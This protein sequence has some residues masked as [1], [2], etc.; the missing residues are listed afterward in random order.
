LWLQLRLLLSLLIWWRIGSAKALWRR[1][2][3]RI[4]GISEPCKGRHL[5]RRRTKATRPTEWRWRILIVHISWWW[6]WWRRIVMYR[7]VSWGLF[8]SWWGSSSLTKSVDLQ[9]IR[10]FDSEIY[11]I[12][13]KATEISTIK[14]MTIIYPKLFIK[15]CNTRGVR[16]IP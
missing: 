16:D 7:R 3:W 6:W 15:E 2:P 12:R 4:V 11:S 1:N 9:M 5:L 13:R 14:F 10:K 8:C